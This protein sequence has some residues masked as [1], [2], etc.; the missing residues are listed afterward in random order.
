M[1]TEQPFIS[2]DL[3]SRLR[4]VRSPVSFLDFETFSPAL[5]AYVGTRP[6]QVI[7]FQWSLHVRDSSGQLRHESFLN[8]DSEDPRPAFV[9]SLLDA[10][11]PLGSIVVYSGYEQTIMKQLAVGLPEF[12]ERLLALC[13]RTF[14][15]LKLVRENYY[16]PEFH[17]SYSI[18]SVLPALVPDMSYGDL[19]M[20]HGS[21]AGIAFVRMIAPDTPI[22]ERAKTKEALLAYCQRDTEA[23]VRVL[24]VLLAESSGRGGFA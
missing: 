3:A 11:P 14:D 9:T 7:P 15:L 20:Q 5:P 16:H 23:M 1:A 17:G 10:V 21:M 19:E 12:A 2:S 4:E 22:P 13:G 6:Y 8:E 18:K 24:D